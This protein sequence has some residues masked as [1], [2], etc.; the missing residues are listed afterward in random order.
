[1]EAYADA[2]QLWSRTAKV[3]AERTNSSRQALYSLT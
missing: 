1:M 2:Q 3:L